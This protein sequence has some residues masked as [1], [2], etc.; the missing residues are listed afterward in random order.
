MY[1]LNAEKIMKCN[2]WKMLDAC[3]DCEK[4]I[5][6]DIIDQVEENKNISFSIDEISDQNEK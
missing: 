2:E 1:E 4:P 5:L 6:N 3:D